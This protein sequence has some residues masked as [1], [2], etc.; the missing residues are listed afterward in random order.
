MPA[1]CEPL[2]SGNGPIEDPREFV[3]Q[4]GLEAEVLPAVKALP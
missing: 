4:L 3:S 2:P 1:I